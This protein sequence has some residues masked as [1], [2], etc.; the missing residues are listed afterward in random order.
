MSRHSIRRTL[1][2]SRRIRF[3]VPE[4]LNQSSDFPEHCSHGGQFGYLNVK[5]TGAECIC[6]NPILLV[7]VAGNDSC[8]KI[9]KGGL[10]SHPLQDFEAVLE[11]H[12]QVQEENSRN[13]EGGAVVVGRL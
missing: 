12:V 10:R 11:R 3:R 2:T 8:W 5:G 1:T 9:F 13:W 6:P 4:S 7:Q